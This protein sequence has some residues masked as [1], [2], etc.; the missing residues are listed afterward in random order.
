MIKTIEI[1][2]DDANAN[3]FITMRNKNNKK[4]N[5]IR[6]ARE[7]RRKNI[8][9]NFERGKSTVTDYVINTT[10]KNKEGIETSQIV[11][12]LTQN[13][14]S[15]KNNSFKC[16]VAMLYKAADENILFT[17]KTGRHVYWYA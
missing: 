14:E 10:S 15:L 6:E 2:T 16:I 3:N 7:L 1:S 8:Q 5:R 13:D 11:K 9:M 4:I 12:W 17:Y